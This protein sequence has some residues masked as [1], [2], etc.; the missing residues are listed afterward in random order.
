MSVAR[1]VLFYARF[2]YARGIV[3]AIF[4][5]AIVCGTFLPLES[6]QV[7]VRSVYVNNLCRL[8]HAFLNDFLIGG[9]RNHWGHCYREVSQ[10]NAELC[11]SNWGVGKRVPIDSGSPDEQAF[12]GVPVVRNHLFWK[13]H[14][15]S[16][17]RLRANYG[18][19]FLGVER[20]VVGVWQV[21]IERLKVSLDHDLSCGSISTIAPSYGDFLSDPLRVIGK[22][23]IVNQSRPQLWSG[24]GQEAPLRDFGRVASGLRHE[25]EQAAEDREYSSKDCSPSRGSVSEKCVPNPGAHVWTLVIFVLAALCFLSGILFSWHGLESGKYRF[26]LMAGLFFILGW[27]ATKYIFYLTHDTYQFFNAPNV[28][29]DSSLHSRGNAE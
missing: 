16:I 26:L 25:I 7:S 15:G 20:K 14:V 27:Y 1:G 24:E 10:L 4:V 13:R 6:S 19:S 8:P 28:V 23:R 22:T 3:I 5:I 12:L 29:C 11:Q 2:F 21:R 17:Y 9:L 18:L